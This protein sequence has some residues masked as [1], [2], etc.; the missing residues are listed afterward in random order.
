[1]Q[2][3]EFVLRVAGGQHF[4]GAPA[5]PL[6][7]DPADQHLAEGIAPARAHLVLVGPDS[8][9]GLGIFRWGVERTVSWLHQFRRL[10]I[11]YERRADVHAAFLTLGCSLICHR[12]QTNSFS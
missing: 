7:G 10:R 8:G 6:A 5:H 4:G 12:Y 2:Y 3:L 9:S 11:R 1:M